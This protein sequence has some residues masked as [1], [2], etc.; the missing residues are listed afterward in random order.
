MPLAELWRALARNGRNRSVN[1]CEPAMAI[2]FA[3]AREGE[4]FFLEAARNRP[5]D[6]FADLDLVDGADRSD[7]NGGS[8]EEDFIDNVKH[9]SWNDLFLHGNA[10]ILRE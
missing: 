5:G 7:F 3:A 8:T 6:A 4:E 10:Q 9:F 1:K 2:R